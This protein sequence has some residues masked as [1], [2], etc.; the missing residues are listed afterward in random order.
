MAS[1]GAPCLGDPTYGSGPPAPIVREA[2]A[3][4]V[5]A[6]QTGQFP[7]DTLHAW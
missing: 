5:Q 2:M 7:D 1:K 6:V 4:Y 3:A